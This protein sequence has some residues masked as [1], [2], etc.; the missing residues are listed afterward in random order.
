MQSQSTLFQTILLTGGSSDERESRVQKLLSA[1]HASPAYTIAVKQAPGEA[2]KIEH[3]RDLQSSLYLK[4]PKGITV[5][6][7]IYEIGNA[8]IEAQQSLL[9]LLEEPPEHVRILMTAESDQRILA[10]IVSRAR[11]LKIQT[12][13]W[14]IS[15]DDMKQYTEEFT[16]VISLPSGKRFERAATVSEEPDHGATWLKNMII[17][18]RNVLHTEVSTSHRTTISEILQKCSHCL[19]TLERTNTNP[20]LLLENLLLEIP[21]QW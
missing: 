17:G 11:V 13:A 4:P 18:A 14:R 20:R 3:V 16:S 9:K 2:I 8:T 19:V 6:A 10:T 5:F 15:P 21:Q 12:R 1:S 7:I